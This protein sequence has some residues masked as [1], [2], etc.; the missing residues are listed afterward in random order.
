MRTFLLAV[1]TAAGL[2]AVAAPVHAH[3]APA[4]DANN[5]YLKLTPMRDRV[6]LAYTVYIGELPGAQARRRM[7]GNGDGTVSE[8]ESESYGKDIAASV[9]ADLEITWDDEPYEL[10]WSEILVGLGTPATNAGSFSVDLIG[11]ICGRDLPAHSL[12]MF[13]RYRMPRPG[14]TEVRLQ[15]TPGVTVTRSMLGRDGEHSQVEYK[16]QGNDGPMATLGYYLEYQVS[17]QA[18]I[19]PG[20]ACTADAGDNE[21]STQARRNAAAMVMATM[22]IGLLVGLVS[23]RRSRAGN[24][25]L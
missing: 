15:A 6:R 10:A 4:M 5:R 16:W 3:V 21:G 14:E 8:R 2:A 20:Q 23:W 13:D 24:Q 9:L 17:D 7:D 18:D 22:L 12:L 19:P 1:T 25:K 11:W